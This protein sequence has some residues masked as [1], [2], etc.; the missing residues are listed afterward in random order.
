MPE[1]RCEKHEELLEQVQKILQRLQELSGRQ[2]TS[3]DSGV[4]ERFMSRD[5]EMELAMG[6]KERLVGA[7][8][9]HDEEHGCQR[10][11]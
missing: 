5:R 9:E 2:V 8:R 1:N 6:E 7:L 10:P 11:S 3:I 4:S